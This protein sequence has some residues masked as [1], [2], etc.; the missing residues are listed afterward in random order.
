MST[1]RN[2]AVP[3]LASVFI[4]TLV[5]G[6]V[7][8]YSYM[9]AATQGFGDPTTTVDF[10]IEEGET[11]EK[12]AQDLLSKSLITNIYYFK[13][14]LRQNDLGGTLQSG[15]FKIPNNLSLKDLTD[16]LQHA[17]FP[18]IWVTIPEGLRATEIAEVLE[19]EFSRYEGTVFSKDEFLST[20]SSPTFTTEFD[21]PAPDGESLEGY[22]FPDT[23]RF[24]PD[25]TTEYIIMTM[26]SI[27][28][29]KNVRPNQSKIDALSSTLSLN[30]I[31][32]LA[33]II[34]RETI[35]PKDRPIV[36]DILRRRLDNGWA[37]EVDVTLLYY[38]E[39]WKHELTFDELQVDTPYNT[40]KYTGLTP[41][42]IS[43]PGTE[44]F[45]AVL[46]PEPNDYWFFV[47]DSEGNLHYA[48]T[49]E[50]HNYNIVT[51][52]Q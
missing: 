39:D 48:T 9:K 34:E 23:Y 15:S 11:T 28:E 20:A 22:L 14:Y 21:N 49:L 31:V 5:V 47:S 50:E 26:L 16:I 3:I 1:A 19:E 37:L 32:T 7:I 30:D 43:N 38:F 4:A 24:P 17:V 40:R 42:P 8:Y 45:G 10:T 6:L 44:S 13:F 46:D 29:E 33:S 36:A 2:A 35:F 41:T 18:D 51:Y 27:F 25:A 52:M 12:I